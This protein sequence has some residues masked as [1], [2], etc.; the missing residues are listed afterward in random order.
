MSGKAGGFDASL[1]L[2]QVNGR[3]GCIDITGT[4]NN[5]LI[6]TRLDVLDLSDTTNQLIVN[7]NAGD[8][9]TFT[10]LGWTAG[11]TTTLNGILYDRYTIGA[12]T[13]LVYTDITQTIT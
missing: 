8:A 10:G 1:N 3:N 9:V 13:L 7:G 12:A 6:F 11:S 2:S 5:S 4:G